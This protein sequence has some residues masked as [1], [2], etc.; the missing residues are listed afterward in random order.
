MKRNACCA[1]VLALL[2]VG[3]ALPAPFVAPGR[4]RRRPRL[5]QRSRFHPAPST[6][7]P[8]RGGSLTS[9]FP[10]PSSIPSMETG[11]TRSLAT[12]SRW[13]AAR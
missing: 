1:F 2:L 5:L 9:P 13:A 6:S 11:H 8:T 4:R 12:A 10:K 3:C 7:S